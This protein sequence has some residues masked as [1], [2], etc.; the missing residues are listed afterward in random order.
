[1]GPRKDDPEDLEDAGPLDDGWGGEDARTEAQDDKRTLPPPLPRPPAVPGSSVDTPPPEVVVAPPPP[2]P[3]LPPPGPGAYASAGAVPYEVLAR[4][5]RQERVYAAIG[6]ALFIG[7][8]AYSCSVSNDRDDTRSEL[9]ET[10]AAK[11]Q[12]ESDLTVEKQA[13]AEAEG[14]V[15]TCNKDRKADQQDAAERVAKVEADLGGCREAVGK[16]TTAQQEAQRKLDEFNAVTQSFQKM[17][18]TGTLEVEI[19]RGEMEVKLPAGVLF[20]S[21][22]AELSKAGKDAIGQVAEVL[23]TMPNR[24]FTIAGHTDNYSTQGTPFHSNWELSAAR[25]VTVTE[26]LIQQ[27]IRADH[28]VAAGYGAGYPAVSYTH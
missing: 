12:V 21:G 15:A 23:K 14:V 18:D 20:A 1:M 5:I 2:P 3:P 27:G 8:V 11:T 19:Q 26:M 22:R 16:M 9:H 7:L 6:G 24:R 17:I 13:K 28:L 25:A 4:R 10:V